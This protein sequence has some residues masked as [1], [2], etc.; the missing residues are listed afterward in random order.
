MNHLLLKIQNTPWLTPKKIKRGGDL[1]QTQRYYY[2]CKC[3]YEKKLLI[4]NVYI[5]LVCLPYKLLFAPE[6]QLLRG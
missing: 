1:E 2:Y 3:Y 4:K 5:F 6:I